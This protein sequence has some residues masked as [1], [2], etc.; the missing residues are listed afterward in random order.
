MLVTIRK[1]DAMTTNLDIVGLTEANAS[2][3]REIVTGEHGQVVLMSVPPGGEIGE[4]VHPNIDQVLIF[5]SGEGRAIIEDESSPVGPGRLVFV[6]AGTKHNFVNAG[7]EDL[8]L[9]TVYAPPEHAPGT[10]HETKE[11][12]DAAE[13]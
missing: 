2:F 9:Y 7:S 10:V 13:A 3:R 1:G 12:A 5:V 8:R 4:E 11:E 6:P